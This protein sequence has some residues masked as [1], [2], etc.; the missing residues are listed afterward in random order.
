MRFS[1]ITVTYNNLRGLQST[2]ESIPPDAPGLFE[3]IVIDGASSDGSAE[4]LRGLKR[5][6]L[7]FVSEPDSGIFDA[8]NKGIARAQGEYCIFMNAG[9][10][11]Y[12]SGTIGQVDEAIAGKSPDLAFGDSVECEGM[13]LW[14]KH[15]RAPRW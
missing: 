8:M 5:E 6:S 12:E 9:D 11:F 3:W 13:Q 1:I 15:A 7:K 2:L 10:R 4:F 14:L